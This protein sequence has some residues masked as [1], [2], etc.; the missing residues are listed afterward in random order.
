MR[1]ISASVDAVAADHGF[2]SKARDEGLA[3]E[4]AHDHQGVR[5]EDRSRLPPDETRVGEIVDVMHRANEGGDQALLL[6]GRKRVGADPVMGVIEIEGAVLGAPKPADVIVDALVDHVGGVTLR[7]FDRERNGGTTG[8]AKEAAPR[9]VRR[10][11]HSLD[12]EVFEGL[13][14]VHRM[15]DAAARKGGVRQHGDAKRAAHAARAPAPNPISRSSPKSRRRAL[16]PSDCSMTW[17][18]GLTTP[19]EAARSPR[20]RNSESTG[21]TFPGATD[22]RKPIARKG[23]EP[24]L[25]RH[26]RRRLDGVEVKRDRHARAFGQHDRRAGNAALADVLGG[27]RKAFLGKL[28]QKRE[29]GAEALGRRLERSLKIVERLAVC[30]ALVDDHDQ[31]VARLGVEAGQKPRARPPQDGD[32]QMCLTIVQVGVTADDR[33]AIG[34][35]CGPQ[36]VENRLRPLFPLG[37]DDVDDGKR[38]PSHRRDVAQIDHHAAPAGEPGIGVDECADEAFGGEEKVPVAIRDRRAI[39]ADRDGALCESEARGDDANVGL[40][41]ERRT[42]LQP[43][44]KR[45]ES[46]RVHVRLLSSARRNQSPACGTGGKSR[47]RR[48]SSYGAGRATRPPPSSPNAFAERGA[49]FAPA[50]ARGMFGRPSHA[51]TRRRAGSGSRQSRQCAC[52]RRA[53][54]SREPRHRPGSSS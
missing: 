24:T 9:G 44:R 6:K 43:L 34:A 8:L 4:R 20:A 7:G 38:A 40:G 16:R 1:R 42:G 11:Q 13:A 3:P 30:A 54:A 35:G 17:L 49:R 29:I 50:H 18:P 47:G 33:N 22:R 53:T 32:R 45:L 39:V 2:A 28:G 37:P 27:A 36:A 25:E 23:L 41:G 26:A 5:C 51:P 15:D 46:P 19:I 10:V 14:E 31:R 52:T 48:A 12:A 21:S